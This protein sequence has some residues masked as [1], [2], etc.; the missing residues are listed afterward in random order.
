MIRTQV[1]KHLPGAKE[2][3]R[4][5]SKG[6]VRGGA[7]DREAMEKSR[8]VRGTKRKEVRDDPIEYFIPTRVVSTF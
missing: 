2:G 8:Y 6:D 1:L 3:E 7:T 4:R 5:E